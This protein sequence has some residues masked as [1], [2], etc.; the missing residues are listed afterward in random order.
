MYAKKKPVSLAI[1]RR[2]NKNTAH[3][4]AGFFLLIETLLP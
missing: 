1:E 2:N 3:R 4:I